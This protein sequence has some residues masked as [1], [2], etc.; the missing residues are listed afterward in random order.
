MANIESVKL[1]DGTEYDI[2]DNISG[3]AHKI[4]T[5]TTDNLIVQTA[6]GD[7]ADSGIAKS[8][9]PNEI[10]TRNVVGA[11]NF[12][13]TSARTETINGITFTVNAD[14]SVTASGIA[15]ADCDF[16]LEEKNTW[17]LAKDKTDR[18]SGC[19]LSGGGSADYY[20]YMFYADNEQG[21]GGQ[22]VLTNNGEVI[23]PDASW[24]ASVQIFVRSGVDFTTPFTFYPMVRL[25]TD[26]DN[27]YEPYAQ[28]N[29]QLTVNK[30]NTSAIA[31]TE[32]GATASK[33]YAVG[34]HFFRG[35]DYCVCISPIAANGSFT[36]NTNY[37]VKSVSESGVK[38]KKFTA[39]VNA[40]GDFSPSLGTNIAIVSAFVTANNTS[41][42]T[43]IILLP[44]YFAP[45][46]TWYIKALVADTM[47]KVAENTSLDVEIYYVERV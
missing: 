21:T 46:S 12:L 38:V 17:Y 32:D 37:K 30:V 2:K 26:T 4:A 3:Y 16:C 20:I 13:N 31:P 45:H 22:A 7:I 43:A 1:P 10:A 6:S 14:K 18:R 24:Y 41:S 15:T 35:G 42:G 9:I 25:A 23:I 11:K 8:V 40:Y 29:R 34:E 19:I 47:V 27:T 36:L 33:S 39:T 44:F 5:P 28:T